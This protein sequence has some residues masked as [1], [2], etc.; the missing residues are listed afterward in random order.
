MTKVSFWQYFKLMKI[1]NLQQFGIVDARLGEL[2]LIQL[3]L[4][5]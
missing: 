4:I 1:D 5:N 2:I 3:K